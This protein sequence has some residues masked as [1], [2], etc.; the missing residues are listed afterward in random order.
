MWIE[1][2]YSVGEEKWGHWFQRAVRLPTEHLE[3]VLAFPDDLDP[4]VWG[5]ETS[6]TAEAAPLRTAPVQHEENAMRVFSWSTSTPALH[7]RYRLEW[8]FRARPEHD[9]NQREFR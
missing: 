8:R 1:Y 3:V 9:V 5:T 2:A 6:M 7:A 4:V